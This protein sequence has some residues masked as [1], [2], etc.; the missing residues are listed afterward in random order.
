MLTTTGTPDHDM[1]CL[2]RSGVDDAVHKPP[3]PVEIDRTAVDR[4]W[5]RDLD[6]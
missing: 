4:R 3:T 5:K 6:L 2:V 1:L